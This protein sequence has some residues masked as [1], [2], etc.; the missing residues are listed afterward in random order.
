MSKHTKKLVD[1][2]CN[3]LGYNF[4]SPMCKELHDHVQECEECQEYI[5]SVKATVKICKNV[6]KEE[7]TPDNVKQNLL[8]MISNK[9]NE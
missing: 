9:C 1:E 5:Q 7:P 2:L 6:Y 3:Y 4:E 8:K